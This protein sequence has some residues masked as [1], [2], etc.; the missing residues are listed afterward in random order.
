NYTTRERHQQGETATLSFSRSR[1]PPSASETP[2]RRSS[3]ADADAPSYSPASASGRDRRRRVM[4]PEER[5]RS[6]TCIVEGCTNYIVNRQRCFRHG[7]GT[8]CSVDGCTS[9]AKQRG[10]C[11]RHGACARVATA[12]ISCL[13]LACER[14]SQASATLSVAC[15]HAHL[16]TRSRTRREGCVAKSRLSQCADWLSPP[17]IAGGSVLCKVKN[18]TRGVKVRGYCWGHGGGKRQYKLQKEAQAARNASISITTRTEE[19]ASS[20][21]GTRSG[22][23]LPVASSSAAAGGGGSYA[24]ASRC[25]F[26]GCESAPVVNSFCEA[27]SREV[28]QPGYVFE[29]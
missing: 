19:R 21:S 13:F 9:S 7:G 4:T 6:R 24:P 22:R 23:S 27:H 14:R 1:S 12:S 10:L 25:I 26:D 15:T 28:V 18:C 2:L 29:L 3:D 8:R 20:S 11:W 5:C 16:L 17:T